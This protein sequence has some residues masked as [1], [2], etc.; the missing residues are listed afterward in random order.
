MTLT[1]HRD[2]S[3]EEERKRND[4]QVGTL[5][6]EYGEKFA[7]GINSKTELGSLKRKLG[8]ETDASLND[9]LRHYKIKK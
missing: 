6:K 7:P 1:R 8:L 4:T 9:V 2:K 5:V 3:G